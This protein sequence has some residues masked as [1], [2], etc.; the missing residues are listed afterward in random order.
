M[1]PPRLIIATHNAKK[2]GEM[3]T[4]LQRRFP[5]TLIQT[6]ADHPQAP[7]PEETG[8]TYSENATI[9]AES[10]FDVLND[11]CVADDA[12]LEI[13]ALDGAPGLYSKRFG[14]EDMSFP[15]KMARIKEML[16]GEPNRKAR[17]RC[18]VALTGPG[19]PTKVFE[20]TF[21]GEIAMDM[22]GSG[23]FGYDPIFFLPERG[24]TLAQLTAD[25]KHAV[26]HRG[27]VLK[28]L[29]DYIDTL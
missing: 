10:A 27:K 1:N 17:F 29:A 6:L 3:V 12:G 9:K 22:S 7:E 20:A 23:G 21:E 4:I 11:W 16:E 15:D 14:G 26:S 8:L 19:H 28:Q 18:C 24:C 25:E 5:S 13:E 2:A